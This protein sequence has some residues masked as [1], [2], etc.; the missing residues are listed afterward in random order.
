MTYEAL[1]RAGERMSGAQVRD[2][3]RSLCSDPRMAAV[4][5]LIEEQ[6][7]LAADASCAI[8]FAPEH[9]CLAHAAGVRYA[10]NELKGRLQEALAV[11]RPTRTGPGEKE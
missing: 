7:E 10:L 11:R 5:R 1:K 3:V 2:S 6:K 8:K 4:V 9:G